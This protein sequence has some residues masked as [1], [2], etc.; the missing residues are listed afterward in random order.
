MTRVIHPTTW[1]QQTF[2]LGFCFF[3]DALYIVSAVAYSYTF[4]VCKNGEYSHRLLVFPILGR[5]NALILNNHI[6]YYQLE[7]PISSLEIFE[8]F[9]FSMFKG[10]V[11]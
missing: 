3:W 8:A 11:M 6:T 4:A 10:K 1:S 2:V 5:R 9:P 7:V